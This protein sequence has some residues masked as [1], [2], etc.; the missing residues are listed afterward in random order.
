MAT[1]TISLSEDAYEILKAKKREGESFSDV[2]RRE[3]GGKK[4]TKAR[5]VIDLVLSYPLEVRESLAESVEEGRRLRESARPR[6]DGNGM[7]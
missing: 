1:K 7:L 2:I 6:T 4:S 5:E 3:L